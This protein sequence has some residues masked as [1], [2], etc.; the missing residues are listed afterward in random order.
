M[1]TNFF[2]GKNFPSKAGLFF[3]IKAFAV[4][5]L[6]FALTGVEA[7]AQGAFQNNNN[8]TDSLGR[9]F[10]GTNG[11]T[12]RVMT[13]GTQFNGSK[14]LGGTE[15][16]RIPGTVEFVSDDG[17][18]DVQTTLSSET[19]WWY[20]N[21]TVKGSNALTVG[22]SGDT[23]YV[24]GD[25][26]VESGAGTRTYAGWFNY[27]GD[28][29]QEIE[30][31]SGTGGTNGY[32]NL[33]LTGAANAAKTIAEGDSV[34]VDEEFIHDAT[35]GL[36]IT[37]GNLVLRG[38][39]QSNQ[40]LDINAT[41]AANLYVT[42]DAQLRI[43]NS[44]TA[45]ATSGDF[46]VSSSA[47]TAVV[48]ES[49]ATLDLAATAGTM[50]LGV[51]TYVDI[52]GTLSNQGDETNFNADSSSTVVYS[53]TGQSLMSTIVSNPYGNVIINTTDDAIVDDS[54]YIGNNLTVHQEV[55]ASATN[56]LVAMIEDSDVENNITFS[57]DEEIV[58]LVQWQG[59]TDNSYFKVFNNANTGMRFQ[60]APNGGAG[61][62]YVAL[63]NEPTA[64][65]TKADDIDANEDISRTYTL[66]YVGDA[67]IDTI[68]FAWEAADELGG[69]T[70][71][72]TMRIAEAWDAGEA[73]QK[74][75]R[76][77]SEYTFDFGSTQRWVKYSDMQ[78]SG[79][80]GI[81]LVASGADNSAS[82]SDRNFD[83]ATTSEIVLTNSAANMISVQPGRWTDPD[84]WDEGRR[85]ET[86]DTVEIE[87]I[88]YTGIDNGPFST[89]T[90]T[91]DEWLGG[92]PQHW[93]AK[94]YVNDVAE[95]ALLVGNQDADMGTGTEAKF[96]TDYVA[97]SG[98]V[99][100]NTNANAWSGNLS[101]GTDL[102]GVYVMESSQFIPVLSVRTFLNA[103]DVTNESIIEVGE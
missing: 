52:I 21:L 30:G 69:W 94:I 5:A 31:E 59:I 71:N 43:A 11:G 68:S 86:T 99:N 28:D 38:A 62:N 8:S 74:I 54:V 65:P 14:P 26:V 92:N 73:K 67:Q 50:T 29:A 97:N 23:I 98:I 88:V 101:D 15:T 85:P 103:G 57:G 39:S 79:A 77:G 22:A 46:N 34:T 76:Q 35:T 90:E 13:T 42:D 1:K 84:T 3:S 58:G 96:G 17:A 78:L 24:S 18:I 4:V 10:V 66:H 25:Y 63:N 48:V 27:D 20:T 51:D 81:D 91:E 56:G 102:N 53:G 12:I 64:I 75:T 36:N 55:D 40:P 70:S 9:Y 60:T 80:K 83:V 2:S 45:S 95:A 7:S 72:S 47:D 32:L 49:G 89:D 16:D 82:N 93:A 87:H 37:D 100:R 41:G 61:T 6:F 44:S 19:S 33:L